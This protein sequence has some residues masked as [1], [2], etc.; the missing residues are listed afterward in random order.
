KCP[1]SEVSS[2]ASVLLSIFRVVVQEV[3]RREYRRGGNHL[4]VLSL[5]IGRENCRM[6]CSERV[7]YGLLLARDQIDAE[8]VGQR[9]HIA[10][11][12]TVTFGIL[13]NQLFDAS[14]RHR[15]QP[16]F[17]TLFEGYSLVECLL[18]R[19]FQIQRDWSLLAFGALWIAAFPRFELIFLRRTAGTD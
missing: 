3:R 12:M 5:D 4:V 19:D 10:P 1:A 2:M 11:R 7:L 16:L 17:I 18:E 14:G 6:I 15:N 13:G 8:S 9:D